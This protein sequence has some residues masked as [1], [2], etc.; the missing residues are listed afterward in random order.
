M[1]PTQRAERSVE[2]CPECGTGLVGGWMRRSREA[3]E[4]PI[5]PTQ[6]TDHV[7]VARTCPVCQP[8]RALEATLMGVA[9]G[10][11]HLG[12]NLE[13]LMA[14]LR[15]D[16]RIPIQTIQWYLK[17][18]YGLKLSA[19]GIVGT[20]HG[21]ARRAQPAVVAVRDRMWVSPVMHADETG[22]R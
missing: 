1:T 11:Q 5:V 17:T 16:G 4:I 6:V 7:F 14:A 9:V 2:N 15:E 10:R 22:W 20:I 18:V 21:V 19:G 8:R 3:I 13:S 12:V